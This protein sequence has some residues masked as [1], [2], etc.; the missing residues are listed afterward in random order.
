VVNNANPGSKE[1][2]EKMIGTDF[3]KEMMPGSSASR[4]PSISES[5]AHSVHSEDIDEEHASPEVPTPEKSLKAPKEL[6]PQEPGKVRYASDGNEAVAKM[7]DRV[8]VSAKNNNPN[9]ES[10]N[11]SFKVTL[12]DGSKALFKPQDGEEHT[13]GRGGSLRNSIDGGTY[14]KREIAFS[15][16]ANNLGVGDITPIVVQHDHEDHNGIQRGSL[17]SWIEGTPSFE[18]D[19]SLSKRGSEQMRVADYVTGNTDRHGGNLLVKEDGTPGLLDHGLA[20]PQNDRDRWIQPMGSIDK[21]VGPLDPETHEQ[22]KNID[23]HALA[24]SLMNNGIEGEATRNTVARAIRLQ[25][26]P[27]MIQRDYPNSH[28]QAI[29]WERNVKGT[30]DAVSHVTGETYGEMADK[31]IAKVIAEEDSQ[32]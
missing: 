22:I 11:S 15:A 17:Q 27:H 32:P 13:D 24:R 5:S 9:R 3:R 21:S 6:G 16:I 20:F 30:A 10:A 4:S 23:T 14:Y 8:I 18:A 31:V 25:T 1:R 7:E 29:A 19:D 12:D 2:V 26:S 28:M